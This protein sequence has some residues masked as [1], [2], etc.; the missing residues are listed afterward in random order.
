MLGLVSAASPYRTPLRDPPRIPRSRSPWLRVI[1]AT[2]ILFSLPFSWS[3]DMSCDNIPK[4]PVSGIDILAGKAREEPGPALVFFA[5]LLAPVALAFLARLT[6]RV[7]RQLACDVIA[8]LASAGASFM[9]LLMMTYGRPNQPLVYPAAW[10]GTLS[11]LGMLGE[12]IV[13]SAITLRLGLA[14][15]RAPPLHVKEARDR[16]GGDEEEEAPRD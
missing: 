16:G 5:L 6:W 11:A 4:P 3:E 12:A 8:A 14:A 9:C 2:V 13:S 15:R 10:V 1:L 7:W